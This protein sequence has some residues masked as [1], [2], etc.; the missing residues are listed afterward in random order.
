MLASRNRHSAV[1]DDRCAS[2]QVTPLPCKKGTDPDVDYGMSNHP[3][4]CGEYQPCQHKANYD[5]K[6][7]EPHDFFTCQ[8]VS[9]IVSF[10]VLGD[11]TVAFFGFELM[12]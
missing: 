4:H 12:Q 9:F 11:R 8:R 3:H 10:S 6:K 7:V 1:W 2:F 5:A